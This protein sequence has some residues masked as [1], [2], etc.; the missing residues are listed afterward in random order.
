MVK[1]VITTKLTNVIHNCI[2]DSVHYL[3]EVPRLQAV[4]ST[5]ATD[6]NCKSFFFFTEKDQ[7]IIIIIDHLAQNSNY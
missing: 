1:L 3:L 4:K 7:G 6:G 5:T 2:N